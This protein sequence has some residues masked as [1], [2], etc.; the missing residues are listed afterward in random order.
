MNASTRPAFDITA[1][2]GKNPSVASR[3]AGPPVT[4]PAAVRLRIA[5]V[6]LACAGFWAMAAGEVLPAT[7]GI[8]AAVGTGLMATL[9]AAATSPGA[10]WLRRLLAP[11]VLSLGVAVVG[12]NVLQDN[13]LSFLPEAVVLLVVCH[14]LVQDRIRDLAVGIAVCALPALVACGLTQTSDLAVPLAISGGAAVMALV[15]MQQLR[16]VS[17]GL[18][19]LV[20]SRPR[21]AT[22][23]EFAALAMVAC[24][25]VIGGGLYLV[26]PKTGGLQLG[27]GTHDSSQ[28][29]S[30][31]IADPTRAGNF[32]GD[33]MDLS[34]RGDLPTTPVVEV[35][36]ASPDLWRS[37][38]LQTYDG[39][40]WD[41][42]TGS[43]P[44][45][46]V[47]DG[48]LIPESLAGSGQAPLSA[49]RS[50]EVRPL[51]PSMIVLA[52]GR[53]LAVIG[54]GRLF[55][56]ASGWVV[57]ADGEFRTMPPYIVR[58]TVMPTVDSVVGFQPRG[59]DATDPRWLQVP[60]ELPQRVRD[61]AQTL[62]VGTS[63]RSQSV[64]AVENYLRSHEQ[65]NLNSPV[66]A[67]GVDAVDD[68][69]FVS[70]QGFCEQ[71][72]SAEVMLLRVAGIPS[73]IATGYAGGK[74]NGAGR[75]YSGSDAHA[76]VE[77][78]LPGVG[79][80][81][82]DPT[83]DATLVTSEPSA[84]ASMWDSVQQSVRSAKGLATVGV[85]L[86]LLGVGVTA[87]VLIRRRALR[88]EPEIIST[89]DTPAAAFRRLELALTE[90][91][92]PRA[93]DET[94][95]NARFRFRSGGDVTDAF[96]AVDEDLYSAN[97]LAPTRAR[98]AVAVLEDLTATVRDG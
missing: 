24:A 18:P 51:Q 4:G 79:W 71:F 2:T 90:R 96:G 36:A 26:L 25:A 63:S 87:V 77:V 11:A 45:Q 86:L 32:G 89:D 27:L 74:V 48:A 10:M 21:V 42:G 69:L 6:V 43:N 8:L 59:V 76:W 41:E 14:S 9:C 23:P 68:F 57:F 39:Q 52:P 19:V 31:P 58:S 35:Q 55:A 40:H 15:A 33:S 44:T 56:S 16:R 38:I 84:L 50:F 60:A 70:H 47:P 64:A 85:L 67:A 94:V 72:A 95:R 61:L 82:S 83:A 46:F 28:S 80:A 1:A 37:N 7:T 3:V 17:D 13:G 49:V 34:A 22:R 12:W 88:P 65:Y 66:P 73:R 53:M 29:S 30:N 54:G 5:L 91:G 98:N 92:Q 81:S 93:R 62:I 78:W 20:A 97:S 75:T